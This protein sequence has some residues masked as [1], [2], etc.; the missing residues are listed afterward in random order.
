MKQP[1]SSFYAKRAA[2]SPAVKERLPIANVH[3]TFPSD[4]ELYGTQAFEDWH[5]MGSCSVSILN[6]HPWGVLEA[7]LT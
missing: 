5:V 3:V 6:L 1:R 4:E 7:L 2:G